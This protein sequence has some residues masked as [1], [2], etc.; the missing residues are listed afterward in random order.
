MK[1][2]AF[3]LLFAAVALTVSAD[4]ETVNGVEW[5]YSVLNG[6]AIVGGNDRF[7]ITAPSPTN[8][9]T[10]VSQAT[11]GCIAIPER[12]GGLPVKEIADYAFYGCSQLTSVSIPN[13]VTNIGCMTFSGCSEL[14]EVV[15]PNNI[16]SLNEY[17]FKDCSS[18]TGITI[19]SSVTCIWWGAFQGCSGL[20]SITI[21][22]S[23]TRINSS[24]FSGC[25][26]LASIV[27]GSGLRI[28]DSID[29]TVL[30]FS[31]CPALR[32]FY[33]SSD[34]MVFSSENGLF[35]SKDGKTLIQGVIG[36]V[37]IPNFVTR[38]SGCA[39]FGY[40][41]LT[42]IAVPDSV[43]SIGWG[44]FEGC[45][46]L[47]SLTIPDSVTDIEDGAFSG[48]T[49]LSAITIPRSVTN[50]SYNPFS[51]CPGLT[52]IHVSPD[53]PVY[54]SRDNCNAIIRTSDNVLMAGCKNTI[55]P[56][57]V[58][59]IGY[60]AFRGCSELTSILIPN[61][62][63]N[64]RSEAF[65]SCSKLSSIEIPE[66]VTSIEAGSFSGSGLSTIIVS[67]NNTKY[68]SRDNCNAIIRTKDNVLVVGC[69]NTT[70]PNGVTRIGAYA[71][72]DCSGLT[73][74]TIPNSV[75]RI[76]TWCFW[77]CSGLTSLVIPDSV[78]S[79]ENDEFLDCYKL[80]RIVIP[81]AISG[82]EQDWELPEGCAVILRSELAGKKTEEGVPYEWF[83]NYGPILDNAD[84]DCEA[85][86]RLFAANGVNKVWECY[87]AGLNP[88]NTNSIFHTVIS[89][90]DGNPQIS[91]EPK[92]NADEEAKR[93]Y[94]VEGRESL[95]SGSWGPTNAASRFF[96][97]NVSLP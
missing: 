14:T 8:I 32:S 12:L 44:A 18:L 3:A 56:Q 91:W 34:N 45:S 76:G 19:P 85:A 94:T 95:A 61:S 80:S 41:G 22:D 48:C 11:S 79:I 50:L 87:V 29:H 4:T 75:T 59:S 28:I 93:T 70:I 54:D 36:D 62:I 10:A 1:N 33:V 64:I 30:S 68:D 63:K 60:D 42:S 43:T 9:V 88:L 84:D 23:V 83:Y 21:P 53:N 73:S 82:Q 72:F 6:S 66:S 96:R 90:Q 7:S 78:T 5:T 47:T 16:Q 71:F 38:I 69:R 52:S 25:S 74:I 37:T 51:D 35:L 55:I 24:A 92:L 31:G 89:I 26:C 58:T 15:L 49:G 57:G 27:I 13:C 17:V 65:Y 2:L 97:V 39:F 40:A 86:G 20:T 67:P 81:N 77:G 46:G